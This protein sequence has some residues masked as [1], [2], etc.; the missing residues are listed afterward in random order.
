MCGAVCGK[1]CVGSGVCEV[2][3]VLVCG[4]CM[5]SIVCVVVR[6]ECCVWCG[7]C[8]VVCGEW[9]VESVVCGV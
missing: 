3:Y 8:V 5:E 7:V 9:C 2:L 6:G 4:E 1:W